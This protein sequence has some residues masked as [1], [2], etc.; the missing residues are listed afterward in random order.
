[1]WK[2]VAVLQVRRSRCRDNGV[3]SGMRGLQELRGGMAGS[4]VH[5]CEQSRPGQS[6][7][8]VRRGEETSSEQGMAAE[9]WDRSRWPGHGR[10][11]AH[12]NGEDDHW[13]GE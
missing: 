13:V 7:P 10:L 8:R 9:E 5:G 6:G 12:C 4:E 11:E 1:M 2:E 3:V